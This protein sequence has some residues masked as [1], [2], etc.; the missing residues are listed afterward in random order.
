VA[1]CLGIRVTGKVNDKRVKVG[2]IAKVASVVG[3]PD[4]VLWVLLI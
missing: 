3:E 1:W 4:S 2:F